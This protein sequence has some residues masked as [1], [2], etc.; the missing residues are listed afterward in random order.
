MAGKC[1][2]YAAVAAY[3]VQEVVI[4]QNLPYGADLPV[5]FLALVQLGLLVSQVLRQLEPWS[6]L[7]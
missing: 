3:L 6:M 7:L 1:P 4:V 5:Q 2:P